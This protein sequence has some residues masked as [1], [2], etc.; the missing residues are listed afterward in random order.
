M[1]NL[2]QEIELPIPIVR[3][4]KYQVNSYVISNG[5]TE[6]SIKRENFCWL[7]CNEKV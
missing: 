4:N 2:E 3:E 7:R 6:K 5:D 1:E